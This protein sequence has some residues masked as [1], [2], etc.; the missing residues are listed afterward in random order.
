MGRT[1]EPLTGLM[2][3]LQ[4]LLRLADPPYAAVLDELSPLPYAALSHLLTLFA[5]ATPTLP[6]IQHIFDYI[7]ARPPLII[8]YLVAAVTLSRK[9][10]VLRFGGIGDEGMVHSVLTGLPTFTEYSDV[11]G[12]DQTS[13]DPE[14]A[15]A[16]LEHFGV[17]NRADDLPL[18]HE[19]SKSACKPSEPDVY[20]GIPLPSP[21]PGATA[22]VRPEAG[23]PPIP[24]LPPP[25]NEGIPAVGD[26]QAPPLSQTG[27]SIS[28][29][30]PRSAPSG[31]ASSDPADIPLPPS[32]VSTPPASP[33]HAESSHSQSI[34]S[35]LSVLKLSD[36]LIVRFPPITPDLCLTRTLGPAS[37]MRTWAQES[38]SQPS[39]DQAEALV[40]AGTDIVVREVLEPPPHE[41]E[42][43]QRPRKGRMR[44]SRRSETRLLVVGA[45]LVLGAAVAVGIRS[46]RGGGEMAD[47][48]ALFDTLG[49]VGKRMLGVFGDTQLGL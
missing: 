29:S 8:V 10:E 15:A 45:V 31:L 25:Y 18:V 46:H 14:P 42:P 36:E 38:A 1:L 20:T 12:A 5:H 39:D 30:A 19:V 49:A 21:T 34:Y 13:P 47:W 33:I 35:L 4:R 48:R 6:L 44:K 43:R 23:T 27:T 40:V 41:K 2:I 3:I 24:D 16:V 28:I 32:P 22:A 17:T 26:H 11:Y 7:L 37:A 9:D